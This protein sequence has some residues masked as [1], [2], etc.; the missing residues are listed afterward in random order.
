[1]WLEIFQSISNEPQ[2]LAPAPDVRVVVA[3]PVSEHTFIAGNFCT[4]T[5]VA[6]EPQQ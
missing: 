4:R 6:L 3:R 2:A 5:L 1:M